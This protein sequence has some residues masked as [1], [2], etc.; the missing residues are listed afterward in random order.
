M[1]LS[2]INSIDYFTKTSLRPS[3]RV[4]KDEKVLSEEKPRFGKK[5]LSEEEKVQVKEL[6]NRDREVRSHEQAHAA[7]AGPYSNGGPQFEYQRG[8]DGKRYAVGGE[9]SID[10]SPVKGDPEAT[11]QK[12]QIIRK[13]AMAPAEPSS[14]DRQVAAKAAQEM[15]KARSEQMKNRSN[16]NQGSPS[17]DHGIDHSSMTD[18]NYTK[19][20]TF[21]K[22]PS[23]SPLIRGFQADFYA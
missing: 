17:Q 23:T 21:R 7:A 1:I 20:A 9:V 6:Q 19:N 18:G 8:P 15:S 13:A 10:S 14:K 4:K 3:S 22:M 11:I 2:P 16:E 5:E 12:M